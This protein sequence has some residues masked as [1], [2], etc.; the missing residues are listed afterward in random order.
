MKQNQVPITP[1]QRDP[2]Q[3]KNDGVMVP[4]KMS[5]SI[6]MFSFIFPIFPNAQVI[7]S[8][9]TLIIDI[10][11]IVVIVIS[12]LTTI[13]PLINNTATPFLHFVIKSSSDRGNEENPLSSKITAKE[14][15]VRGLLLALE[16]ESANAI[17][18]MG[19]FTSNLV[20]IPTT[21]STS[22]FSINNFLFFVGI[23]SVRI[24]INQTLRRSK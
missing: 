17:L 7:I 4:N 1:T 18:K 3:K 16:L 22:T 8:I 19:V 6:F 11:A 2:H 23:F 14:N 10:F 15:F 21:A 13:S 24:A 12:F 5:G 20:G 9:I